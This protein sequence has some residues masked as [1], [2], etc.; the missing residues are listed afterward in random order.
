MAHCDSCVVDQW[1]LQS[2]ANACTNE[3]GWLFLDRMKK[4]TVH[5]WTRS[6]ET[7]S[8]S[9]QLRRIRDHAMSPTRDG[10]ANVHPSHYPVV[11]LPKGAS[12]QTKR[13][14]D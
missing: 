6:R 12:M 1:R 3:T 5:S 9:N 2:I 4:W 10:V 7:V 14:F 13:D 11:V 8:I